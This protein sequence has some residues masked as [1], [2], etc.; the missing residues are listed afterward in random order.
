MRTVYAILLLLFLGVVMVFAVQN[1][2]PMTV[3]FATYAMNA[4]IALTVIG[5]YILGM[6]SG[7]TVVGLLN[8]LLRRVTV[9]QQH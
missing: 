8:R 4:P 1:Q 3:R 2:Q 6:M 7:A 5:A 9:R